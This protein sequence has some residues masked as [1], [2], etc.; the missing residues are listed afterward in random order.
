MNAM[1]EMDANETHPRQSERSFPDRLN[2]GR[3]AEIATPPFWQDASRRQFAKMCRGFN[4]V[5]R[6]RHREGRWFEVSAEH[7]NN[8]PHQPRRLR[9]ALIG[10]RNIQHYFGCSFSAAELM[11]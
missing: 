6:F 11:Q 9:R 10:I 5:S 8:A 2:I 4:A 3:I 7:K 1:G